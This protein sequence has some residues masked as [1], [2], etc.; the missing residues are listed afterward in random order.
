[1]TTTRHRTGNGSDLLRWFSQSSRACET[2]V[3]A[4]AVA[5]IMGFTFTPAHAACEVGLNQVSFFTDAGFR[6]QCVVKDFGDFASS[7]A[8]GLPNDSISSVRVGPNAQVIVC[9]DNN[10]KGDCILLSKDVN[11]L[12]GP[13]VG[14]D[15]VSSAKVQPLG[16]AQCIPGNRQ[17]SFFTNA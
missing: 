9:K 2:I 4:F 7:G 17:V 11:F 14:N 1:T 12:N 6:G 16:T 8:I 5:L 15:Q 13:R 10:F 3:L